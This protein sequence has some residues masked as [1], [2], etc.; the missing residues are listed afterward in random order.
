MV[1]LDSRD[2]GLYRTSSARATVEIENTDHM[3]TS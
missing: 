3:G 1:Q 2:V